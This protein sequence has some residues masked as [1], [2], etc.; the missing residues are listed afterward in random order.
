MFGWR[1]EFC[2]R[3]CGNCRSIWLHEPP[4]AGALARY[5]GEGYYSFA[6]RELSGLKAKL[7]ELRDRH[8]LLGGSAI[9]ALLSI[10]RNDP[11]LRLIGRRQLW[12]EMGVAD[13]GCGD[14]WLL[15]RFRRA[16]FSDLTGIDPF[17]SSTTTLANG[18]KIV[19]AALD[20]I[21]RRFDLIMF[22]H[23][24]EHVLDPIADL[25]A[26]HSRLRA[27]GRLVVRLPTTSSEAWEEYGVDWFQLD[28]PRHIAIP[29]R[30]GFILAAEQAGFKVISQLD[31][32]TEQ[33]FRLSELYR[34]NVPLVESGNVRV[35]RAKA[36]HY[37]ARAKAANSTNRGDQVIY[38]LA[39]A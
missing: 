28:A 22:N 12:G 38:E 7:I 13:V 26:A 20:Q 5:Y 29:S 34:A 16:G 39:P 19:R 8:L 27:G 11:A 9:G 23:S 33:Q 35:S 18:V 2:Y 15:S 36:A 32:S 3:E 37:A 30:S 14:G 24:L 21:D 10:W 17:A 31:D 1:D 4:S 25:R 6:F